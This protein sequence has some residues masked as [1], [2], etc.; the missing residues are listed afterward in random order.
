MQC[1]WQAIK[2][3]SGPA[4][5]RILTPSLVER[6]ALRGVRRPAKRRAGGTAGQN[7]RLAPRFRLDSARRNGRSATIATGSLVG[8]TPRAARRPPA[9]EA[10]GRRNRVPKRASCPAI[11]PRLRSAEWSQRDHCHRFS[12][13]WR[14]SRCEA[15]AG[16]RS[17]GP[18]EP[19]AKTRV[20]PR[21]SA[22]TPLGGMV[23]ARPLPPSSGRN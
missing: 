8:G 20:L 14:A 7:A 3:G 4:C 6:L 12:G 23:A 5:R 1:R 11:P 21:D 15:S 17:A 10:Q 2:I 9:S 18:A 13:W 19:R 22:S 16:Q